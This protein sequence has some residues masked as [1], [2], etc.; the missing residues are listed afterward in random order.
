MKPKMT[1]IAWL[2]AMVAAAAAP[3]GAEPAAAQPA[4]TQSAS[5]AA[6]PP[7]AFGTLPLQTG[8]VLS[9]DGH[10]LAW[11]DHKEV[12]PRIV[13]FDVPGRKTQRILAVPE[14]SKLRRLFWSDNQ[15]LIIEVSQ[16]VDSQVAAQQSREYYLFVAQDVG[17]GDGRLLPTL[18]ASR[19]ASA[20]TTSFAYLV[21]ART[22]K[23]RTVLMAS[24]AVCH[25]T[26][27]CLIE[28]DTATGKAEII[29][30]GNEHTV[31]W[32]VDRNGRAL[33]REDWDWKTTAYR[34]YALSG[35]N[36]AREIL[37]RDDREPPTMAGLLP[38]NSALV[39]LATNGRTHKAAWAV[40]LDGS[41]ARVLAEDPDTDITR[42]YSD[43]DT[44]AIVGVYVSGSKTTLR[45]L[46]PAAQHRFDVLQRTFPGRYIDIEGWSTDGTKTLAR[47]E[48]PSTPPV[49]YLVDFAAHRADIAAEEY[50]ALNGVP[51]GEL[52]EITYKARDGTAIPAYLTLPPGKA[53][54][55][56]PLVVLP[57]GGPQARDYPRF[58][59]LVQFIASRGYAVLQPQFRGSTGFGDAF[60][61]AGYRQWGG[62]MQD[63]VTDGVQ[64]MIDQGVADPHR[65]GIVGASYGGYAALAGAAFTPKLYKCAASISGVSDIPALMQAEVPIDW[66]FTHV[67]SAAQSEWKERIGAPTDRSLWTRSPINSVATITIPILLIYGTG[68]A[69]VPNDQSER[70]AHALSSAGK[71]VTVATLAGEDHWMSRTQTRVQVLKELDSFLR[72]NL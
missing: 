52:K 50:P 22:A 71:S 57:H 8:V 55:P 33:V 10:W 41:P 66:G 5:A 28:V 2:L 30:G 3:A 38:D 72:T 36:D 15:T 21:R 61:Q 20:Q 7:E 4:S 40:P 65:I 31:G 18:S 34:V 53:A 26:A 9:P 14:R 37:R 19:G 32:L 23:P 25:F 58:D 69:I 68:D 67:V 49:Y 11:I 59:W 62:L 45:W 35:E 1:W 17:G 47:V 44:G 63:D 39:L 60:E 48:T 56:L 43:P 51:L 16:A 29:K 42:A 64:A 54:G 24:R 27:D 6:P 46:E 12:R 13:M 70:M